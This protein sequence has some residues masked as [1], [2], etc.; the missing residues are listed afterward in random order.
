MKPLPVFCYKFV[1]QKK[2]IIIS[3]LQPAKIIMGEFHLKVSFTGL[4]ISKHRIRYIYD[5][6]R[7]SPY[8][9]IHISP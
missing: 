9:G 7:H 6:I 8:L 2:T 4:L 3:I 5:V 1:V